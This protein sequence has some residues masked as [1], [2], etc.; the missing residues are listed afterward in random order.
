MRI[1]I[2]ED[3]LTDVFF[4]KQALASA[5]L[6]ADVDTV[7]DAASALAALG[8]G[9]Y[10]LVLVDV[11][12]PGKSG[13]ELIDDIRS[14]PH[15]G[16][17]VVIVLSSSADES[18]VDKAYLARANAYIQKPIGLIPLVAMFQKLGGFWADCAVL[19]PRR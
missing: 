7:P 11:R 2:V 5:G 18:D 4:A 6:V 10:D 12:L 3:N 9:H 16:T 14:N 1:L 8:A 15:F 17:Q 19:P 13:I